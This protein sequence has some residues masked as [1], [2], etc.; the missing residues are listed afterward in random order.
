MPPTQK[1]PGGQARTPLPLQNL[2]GGAEQAV[3]EGEAVGEGKR[4]G[5]A[6]CEDDTVAE[7]HL[8]G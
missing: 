3:E 4:E 8:P 6:D 2:P 1:E 7:H 5:E